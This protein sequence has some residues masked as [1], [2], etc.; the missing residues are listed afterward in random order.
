MDK[1]EI[2]RK[3]QIFLNVMWCITAFITAC[4]I[5]G[6]DV[7][8]SYIDYKRNQVDVEYSERAKEALKRQ[9]EGKQ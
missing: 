7:I 6:S 5:W 9:I 1:S 8:I 3:H 4:V 2:K